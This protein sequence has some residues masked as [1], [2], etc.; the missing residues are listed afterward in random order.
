MV[1]VLLAVVAVLVGAHPQTVHAQGEIPIATSLQE[2]AAPH[3]AGCVNG[4][5][6]QSNMLNI[7]IGGTKKPWIV[8]QPTFIPSSTVCNGD[9][10]YSARAKT[11]ATLSYC[12]W[13]E[14]ATPTGTPQTN[15]LNT[16]WAAGPS[17]YSSTKSAPMTAC[18]TMV[19]TNACDGPWMNKGF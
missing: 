7:N 4:A 15:C 5:A 12:A 1:A 16:S 11:Q 18:M 3:P 2:V 13:V 17:F 14:Y 19:G 9:K 6:T 10:W 8:E